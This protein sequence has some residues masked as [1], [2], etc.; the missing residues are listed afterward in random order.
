MGRLSGMFKV[1]LAAVS[2]CVLGGCSSGVNASSPP[3]ADITKV[4]DVKSSFGPEFKVKDIPKRTADPASFAS[5]T[6]PPGVIFHPP[7]CAKV[8]L[9]PQRPPSLQATVAAVSAEDDTNRFV[10]VAAETSAP[11]PSD[12]PGHHCSKIAISGAHVQGSIEV[13]DTPKIEGTQTL[14]V[15]RVL[16]TLDDSGRTLELYHYSAQFG[17]YQVIVIASPTTVPDQPDPPVDTQRA[18]D[19]LVKAVAAIRS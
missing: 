2:I 4:V 3:K 10:V 11:L 19:L 9:G 18:R 8:A 16:R 13:V 7:E 6:L 14:G 1:V 5:H 17:D 15:H 12:D